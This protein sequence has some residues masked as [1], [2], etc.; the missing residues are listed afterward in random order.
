MDSIKDKLNQTGAGRAAGGYKIMS[1]PKEFEK[2]LFEGMDI[3]FILIFLS[4]LIVVFTAVIILANTEY[5]HE[6]IQSALKAQYIQKFY[7]TQL[8]EPVVETPKEEQ[9][10]AADEGA[11]KQEEKKQDVRAKKDVGKRQEATGTS[12]AERRARNRRNAA[13]RAAARSRAESRVAGTGVLNELSA[14]GS[15]ASGD[16]VYDV[17]GESSDAGIGD[18]DK[19][20][21][22]GV[23]GLQSASS[24]NR[25]SSLGERAGKGG[26][27]GRAGIDDLIGSGAGQS[28]SVNISRSGK[29]N[30]KAVKGSISG[31]GSK[32]ANRSSDAIGK[33]VLKHSSSVEN[34]YK[35]EARLNPN[36]K[37]SVTVQFTITPNGKVSR[38]RVSKTTL[39]NRKV[40]SCITNKVKRWR[41]AK[42][43]PKDGDVT[44]RYKWV[45][46]H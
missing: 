35:R 16:A 13:R 15:G 12:A 6:A 2:G 37:G 4:S 14:A 46:S 25:R 23:G 22:S 21:A 8:E 45:F 5:S 42:I 19:A 9:T 28:G 36:L 39:R 10:L 29:F 17:L 41:F 30:I 32:S 11:A 43:N 26:G 33:V 38:A 34:C 18:L 31:R 24:S 27:A 7:N 44:A 1:F 20:L 3:R 40:E